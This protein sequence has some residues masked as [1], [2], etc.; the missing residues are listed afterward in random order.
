MQ[1]LKCKKVKLFFKNY[2]NKN[3]CLMKKIKSFKGQVFKALVN[4]ALLNIIYLN[5]LIVVFIHI[6]V[7]EEQAQIFPN[8][9]KN[10]IYNNNLHNNKHLAL[11][12]LCR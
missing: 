12:Q 9:N 4:M 11:E 8:L 5:K 10:K 7:L 3:K 1:S 6:K 2:I